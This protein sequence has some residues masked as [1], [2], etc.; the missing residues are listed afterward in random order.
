MRNMQKNDIEHILKLKQV[1]FLIK[2]LFDVIS[3]LVGLIVIFPFAIVISFV[4]T[5]FSRTS[6][7]F[8]QDRVGK[9]GKIFTIY[10]FNTMRKQT[11]ELKV[12]YT[13]D[14]N[15]RITKLGRFLRKTKIDEIPQLINVLKGDMS[16]V[17]PRPLVPQHIALYNDYQKQVLLVKPGITDL[18][19]ITF[20]KESEM[21]ANS[22]DPDRTYVEEIIPKKVTLNLEY[23]QKMSLHY[24]IY[25]IFKTIF[26]LFKL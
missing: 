16:F 26:S 13:I 7:I 9:N 1:Y 12:F 6:P 8:S 21:L 25:L 23:I 24:D 20:R 22:S 19:S 10:K 2:R 17:G 3:S 11:E 4:I 5:S 18:A 14:N 15:A